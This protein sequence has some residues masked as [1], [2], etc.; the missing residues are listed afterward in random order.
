MFA[1]SDIVLLLAWHGHPRQLWFAAR[2]VLTVHTLPPGTMYTCQGGEVQATVYDPHVDAERTLPLY[3]VSRWPPG[4]LRWTGGPRA[5]RRM[6]GLV[7][8]Q[9]LLY[10]C[11]FVLFFMSVIVACAWLAVAV[12]WEWVFALVF[13]LEWQAISGYLGSC[14]YMG[15]R[16]I[17][18]LLLYGGSQGIGDRK[19]SLAVVGLSS[20]H[21]PSWAGIVV[22]FFIL[23]VLPLLLARK[24][25]RS[26][27]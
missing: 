7:G 1:A 6:S 26:R 8:A 21:F 11:Y 3:R 17:A 15:L 9:L 4:F 19:N 13:F 14:L 23:Y 2:L 25:S 12:N 5:A 16:P 10:L 27:H 22:P 18:I 20:I 24:L